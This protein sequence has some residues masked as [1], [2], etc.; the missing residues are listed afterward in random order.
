M[1]SGS[2]H[3]ARLASQ[4][5]PTEGADSWGQHH[6]FSNSIKYYLL[7]ARYTVLFVDIY[8]QV[9]LSGW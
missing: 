4:S 9:A 2:L 8:L 1:K 5:M 7:F 6:S 3:R